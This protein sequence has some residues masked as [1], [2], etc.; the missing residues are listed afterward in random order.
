MSSARPAVCVISTHPTFG[1]RIYY[2]ESLSLVK[3]GYEVH[4]IVRHDRDEVVD[5]VHIHAL[6]Q[7]SSRLAKIFLWPWLAFWKVLTDA[8]IAISMDGVGRAFDNIMVNGCG[9]R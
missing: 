9:G 1:H 8:G 5:G 4:L 6:P 7:S 3:A 2:K